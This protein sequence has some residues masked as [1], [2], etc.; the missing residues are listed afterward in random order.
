MFLLVLKNMKSSKEDEI[1][2]LFL[3]QLSL[4]II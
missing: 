4:T 3:A 1:K 2:V